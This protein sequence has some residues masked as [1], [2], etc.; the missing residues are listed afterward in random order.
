MKYIYII[1]FFLISV[2]AFAKEN[3]VTLNLYDEPK[4]L[5]PQKAQDSISNMIIGHAF[6]GLTRLDQKNNPIMSGAESYKEISSTE[7]EFK[8]REHDW[9]DGKRVTAHDYVYGLRRGVDPKVAS[10]YSFILYY[11][12]NAEA[13]NTKKMPLEELGVTAKDDQTLII[14]LEKPCPYF[15]RLVSTSTYFPAR[16]D[17]VE[18]WKDKYASEVDTLVFNGPFVITEWK[19]NASLMMKKNEKYWNAKNIFLDGISMPYLIRDNNSEFNMFK[20][21][22]Y[23]LVWRLNKDLLPQTQKLKMNIKSFND[24][25]VWMF[26][27]NT[28]NKILANKNLRKA[29]QVGISRKEYISQ[30][31]GI[32]G[33]KPAFGLIPDYMPSVK[34]NYG[35]EFP[36][37]FDDGNII[38]A[39]KYLTEALKE[40]KLETL[41]PIKMLGTD[42]DEDRKDLEYFQ[43]YLKKNLGIDLVLD[44]QTFKVRIEKTNNYD[45]EMVLFGWGPDYLDAMTF[46]DLYTSWNQN[47]H[48]GWGSKLLDDK[49]KAGLAETNMD[50]RM[51]LISEINGILVEDA[52]IIPIYQRVWVYVENPKVKGIIRRAIGPD[53][54]FYFTKFTP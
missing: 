49:V 1:L 35:K 28:K 52:P 5:D 7:Y 29:I 40:L 45:F 53:P 34:N 17:I 37:K 25:S 16:K 47:N 32:P 4:D 31:N 20:D 23:D 38:Q 18:K 44:F 3:I 54:D 43:S 8:I 13:V 36:I 48:S 46:A 27:F 51:Q 19:H 14:K 30:V 24:G 6:E 41:P 11:I 42:K 21:G 12:K 10:L 33:T 15:L 26:V 9:S 2:H 39:K 22:K 50:I